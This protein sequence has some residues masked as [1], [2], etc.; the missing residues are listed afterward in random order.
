MDLLIRLSKWPLPGVYLEEGRIGID[1][2]LVEN[3]IRLTLL[4]SEC[5]P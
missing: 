5:L 1:N 3:A 2:N 4:E